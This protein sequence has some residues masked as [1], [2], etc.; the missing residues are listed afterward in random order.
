MDID[1]IPL[2]SLQT[3][4]HV[5][6]K[7]RDDALAEWKAYRDTHALKSASE[8]ER[9]AYLHGVLHGVA[10]A[11]KEFERRAPIEFYG[12]EEKVK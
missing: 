10:L 1:K 3:A 11:L 6:E 12:S 4:V 5:I 2:A 9:I 8:K 7:R